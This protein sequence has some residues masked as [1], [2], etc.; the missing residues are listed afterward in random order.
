MDKLYDPQTVELNTDLDT[1]RRSLTNGTSIRF[2]AWWIE[3][4]AAN[5]KFDDWQEDPKF[6][7]FLT[8]VSEYATDTATTK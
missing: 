2:I 3:V 1:L 6:L 5:D 7:E 8:Q 4:L